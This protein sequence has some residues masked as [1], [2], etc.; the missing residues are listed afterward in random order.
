MNFGKASV[1]IAVFVGA[2]FVLWEF[3]LL[4]MID[5]APG[6]GRTRACHDET[7]SPKS[8]ISAC[9]RHI[10]DNDPPSYGLE[11]VLCARAKAH[12]DDGQPDKAKADIARVFAM[13]P[14]SSCANSASGRMFLAEKKYEQA[15]AAYTKAIEGDSTSMGLWH[16]RAMARLQMSDR[17][18]AIA[19]LRRALS[20]D[21]A[22]EAS[23]RELKKLGVER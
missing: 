18:G 14:Q 21:P 15:M 8:R 1:F 9:S 11:A 7:S 6:S 5:P 19:D 4:P 17:E 22:F 20:I 10:G 13:Y 3:V 2:I 23:R 12:V 16:Q